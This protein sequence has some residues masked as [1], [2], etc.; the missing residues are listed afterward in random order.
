MG[1]KRSQLSERVAW[2]ITPSTRSL[3]GGTIWGELR[4]SD[5]FSSESHTTDS[6]LGLG[7][8]SSVFVNLAAVAGPV[9]GKQDALMDVNYRSAAPQ[10]SLC[11]SLSSPFFRAPAAAGMA[12]SELQFGHWIQSSTQATNAERSGQVAHTPPLACLMATHDLQVPYARAKAMC[13]YAL[14]NMN[15]IPVTICLLGLLY[16]KQNGLV[17]Q[18]GSDLN[19]SDLCRLPLTPIMGSGLAPLQPHEVSDAAERIT[20][21]ALTDPT[22]RPLQESTKDSILPS[23]RCNSLRVYDAVGP[24]TMTM[25]EML[26][27]L[28]FLQNPE[29]QFRPVHIDYRNMERMLNV[30][31]LGASVLSFCFTFLPLGNMNRQFVSLLRSE[32][33]TNKP[34]IGNYDVWEKLIG[35]NAKLT[36][37][38]DS[39]DPNC[40]GVPPSR[41]FPI[42]G[43]VRWMIKNPGVILPGAAVVLETL[44]GAVEQYSP[45]RAKTE[46]KKNGD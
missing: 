40:G 19:L 32:Q 28:R 35:E 23:N 2:I 33:D 44:T 15:S 12:C 37:L 18:Q 17:G 31:S 30:K 27:V 1:S 14:A 21:L 46:D 36:T 26:R 16:S 6:A 10:D 7:G 4:R 39:F 41:K 42:R 3:C 9:A 29:K 45:F 38:H 8:E 24:E 5:N 13:D 22:L 25:M 20:W 43:L 11:L 34:V